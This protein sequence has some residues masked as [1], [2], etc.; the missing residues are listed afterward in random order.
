M[1]LSATA[2]SAPPDELLSREDEDIFIRPGS[3]DIETPPA[4][5]SKNAIRGKWNGRFVIVKRL[6]LDVSEEVLQGHA[7]KW[8]KLMHPH[9]S[10]ICGIADHASDPLFIVMPFYNCGNIR[11]YLSENPQSNRHKLIL[12]IASGMQYLHRNGIVHGGLR[13]SNIFLTDDEHVTISEY[14]MF[15]LLQTTKDPEAHRYFSPEVWKGTNSRA[16]DIYAFAMCALEIFTS[17]LPWGAL[18]E[19]HIYHLVMYENA[20]PERPD[21]DQIT[22]DL[23]SII[24]SAWHPEP[25]SRPTFDLI[26]RLWRVG[27][28]LIDVPAADASNASIPPMHRVHSGLSV[29]S[30]NSSGSGPP[31]YE[32]VPVSAPPDL[33]QFAFNRAEN[34]SSRVEREDTPHSYSWY[35]STAS[36]DSIQRLRLRANTTPSSAPAG[37]QEFPANADTSMRPLSPSY[38]WYSSTMGGDH[39]SSAS[40][41]SGRSVDTPTT[42]PESSLSMYRPRKGRSSNSF[43]SPAHAQLQAFLSNVHMV[44]L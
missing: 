17:I 35:S 18:S 4:N 12:D 5:A 34:V 11:Q 15:E 42:P 27:T 26:V 6:A 3:L 23:W 10:R 24:V 21:D 31:A 1:L 44:S 2:M 14:G 22:D 8:L 16:S 25:R 29:G 38:S 28:S 30:N 36:H 39:Q 41:S 9:V 13:P 19:K 20:R 33:Q 40:S 32:R 43:C 37:M 7:R